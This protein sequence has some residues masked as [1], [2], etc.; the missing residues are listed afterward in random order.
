MTAPLPLTGAGLP[1]AMRAVRLERWGSRP[2]LAEVPVPEPA[3]TQVLLR[4]DAAGLCH[5]D[6]HVMDAPGG[7][8][9]YELP[10]TLGHE[11]VG[12]VVAAG[13]E[14][15]PSWLGTTCVVHGVWSCGGC[16]NCRAGRDNYCTA[17]TGAVGGGLGYDGGLAEYALVP[18]TRHL[19]PASGADPV[20]LAPL[21]DAGLTAYHALRDHLPHVTGASVAVIGVGGLGHLAVQLLARER[22]ASLVAVDPRP[23]ASALA[24]RLGASIAVPDAADLPGAL[25]DGSADLVI[26]FVGAQ[27]TVAAVAHLA[28]GGDF[29]LVGSA[30]A[31]M[32]TGKAVGL[33]RG[34]RV[35]APFWGPQADLA[36]VVDLASQG[37]LRAEVQ[38]FG[39]DEALTAYDQL[40]AGTVAG[41]AVVVPHGG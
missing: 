17:L 12:T 26:D 40:R 23:Q 31:P 3:G 4:V 30:G 32:R 38:R 22:P 13:P 2:E 15:E 37:V 10:F 24:L 39:L 6:L 11:I 27:A 7:T 36:A 25:P 19:V 33:N 1:A 8:M 28:P 21:T 35:S 34:W 41:R 16:R 20:S 14:A 5:S 9:P 18:T 29:V